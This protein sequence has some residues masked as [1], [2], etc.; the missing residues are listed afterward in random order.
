MARKS[1][2]TQVIEEVD[3]IRGL[4]GPVRGI[5][6]PMTAHVVEEAMHGLRRIENMCL[7]ARQAAVNDVLAETPLAIAFGAEPKPEPPVRK[8]TTSHRAPKTQ[9]EA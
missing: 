4:L 9:K 5:S 2:S 7:N 3:R 6:D 1:L 8:R